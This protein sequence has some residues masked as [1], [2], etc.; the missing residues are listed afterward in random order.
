MN[1]LKFGMERIYDGYEL[2]GEN[3]IILIAIESGVSD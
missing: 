2:E 3:E 1:H